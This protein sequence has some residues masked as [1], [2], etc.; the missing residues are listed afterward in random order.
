M[1]SVICILVMPEDKLYHEG[2]RSGHIDFFKGEKPYLHV[3]K[4][5]RM[6]EAKITK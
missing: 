1:G 3:E 4:S 6:N 5:K 2:Q